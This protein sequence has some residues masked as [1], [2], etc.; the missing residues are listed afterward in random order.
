MSYYLSS[1]LYEKLLSRFDSLQD[2][3]SHLQEESRATGVH[4]EGRW[5]I[6]DAP[7]EALVKR[8]P[9]TTAEFQEI[10]GIGKVSSIY[11]NFSTNFLRPA[12]INMGLGS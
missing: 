10:E 7:L 9:K 8:L 11:L 12:Q 4:R 1:G 2:F 5:I 6:E 3:S